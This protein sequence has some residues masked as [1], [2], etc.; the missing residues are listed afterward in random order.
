MAMNAGD[1]HLPATR[2]PLM[3]PLASDGRRVD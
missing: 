2:L 1:Q 3:P